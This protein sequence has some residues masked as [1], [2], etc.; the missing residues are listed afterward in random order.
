MSPPPQW[1][2][3]TPPPSYRPCLREIAKALR[4]DAARLG[5]EGFQLH[6]N[7]ALHYARALDAAAKGKSWDAALRMIDEPA[8]EEES[9]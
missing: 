9:A 2:S 1:M 4:V 7:A 6:A 3:T 8:A 5:R